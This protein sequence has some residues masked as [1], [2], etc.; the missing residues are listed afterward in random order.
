MK[1]E[2]VQ[3]GE[4]YIAKVSDKLTTVRITGESRHGGWD[5]IN[6]KTNKA[7]R[8]KSPQRLRGLAD[9]TKAAT[10]P[11]TAHG[12]AGK[13]PA[14]KD[15]K[16][17]EAAKGAKPAAT[18]LAEDKLSPGAKADLARVRAAGEQPDPALDKALAT[19]GK[20]KAAKKAKGPKKP[21]LL[22]LAAEVLG[23]AGKPMGCKEIVEEVL[24]SGRWTTKGRT[25][26]ATLYSAILREVA[27]P[28]RGS[29][30]KKV[31]RG[32]FAATGTKVA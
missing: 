26:S 27:N 30:F 28:A 5:A 19:A 11:T 3:I 31:D 20:A 32:L 24:K 12:A 4:T 18:A 2:Q 15:T 14:A 22:D 10:T 6:T 16:K 7:I 25:P 1:K 9:P 17:T 13:L 23:K 8:I 29:R 21:S